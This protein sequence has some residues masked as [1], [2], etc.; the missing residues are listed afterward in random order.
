LAATIMV[1]NPIIVQFAAS[2]HAMKKMVMKNCFVT[3]V[4]N[5]PAGELKTWTS[6]IQLNM[7]KVPFR[8]LK[9]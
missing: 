2:N 7:E 8:I 3:I 9:N 6:G 1:I 4:I 5:F